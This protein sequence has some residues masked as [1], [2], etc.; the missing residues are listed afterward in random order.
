M[1][2]QQFG[3]AFKAKIGTSG[4][5]ELKKLVN[6]Q[7]IENFYNTGT[8]YAGGNNVQLGGN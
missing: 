3:N 7:G 5:D 6:D 1:N 4:S 2:R 8:Q